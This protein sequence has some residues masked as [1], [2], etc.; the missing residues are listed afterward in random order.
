MNFDELVSNV[1]EWAS[2][3]GILKPENSSKQ[4]L[5]V[6]EEV[7][8]TAGALAKNDEVEL[9]D[10]IGDSFVTLIILASQCGFEPS[11]CLESA[12]N[13][14]KNRKGKTINGIFIKDN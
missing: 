7:G 8:E 5:K 14:I 9:K 11:E 13:E 1:L 2:E 12:W 10:G 4:M 3:K 6:M